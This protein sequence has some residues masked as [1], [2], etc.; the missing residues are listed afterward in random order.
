VL[1]KLYPESVYVEINP[2]DART[3]G[4]AP[5]ERV[6][7]ESQ[8]DRIKARAFITPLV[9]PGQVFIPMHYESTNRLTDA[10]FDPYSR[11]PSYKSCAVRIAREE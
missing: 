11:Q 5:N 9:Q 1:R 8:R 6:V 10:V 4:I 3:L 7:V 2:A